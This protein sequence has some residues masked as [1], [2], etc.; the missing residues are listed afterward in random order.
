MARPHSAV[1]TYRPLIVA[2]VLVGVALLFAAVVVTALFVPRIRLTPPIGGHGGDDVNITER[3]LSRD[4]Q[5]RYLN[6]FSP[7]PVPGSA[8]DV[9][10]RHQQ[11]QDSFFEATFTL[12]PADF[13]AYVRGLQPTADPAVFV[14]KEIGPYTGS[15]TVDAATGRVTLRH[16]SA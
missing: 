6:A 4:E 11:F 5:M 9:R 16:V 7:A 15:V 3:G 2:L 14:G 12:P 13:A 8:A 10:L 1:R